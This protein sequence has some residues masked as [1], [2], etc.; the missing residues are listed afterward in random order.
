MLNALKAIFLARRCACPSP[1]CR[2]GTRPAIPARSRYACASPFARR[3]AVER[4]RWRRRS[5]C[6]SRRAIPPQT[7]LTTASICR[8][9]LSLKTSTTARRS[10][11]CSRSCTQCVRPR[12]IEAAPLRRAFAPSHF[13]GSTCA[14]S[15]PMRRSDR[16]VPL[17]RA[18]SSRH[19]PSASRQ[20]PRDADGVGGSPCAQRCVPPRPTPVCKLEMWR[21]TRRAR[22]VHGVIMEGAKFAWPLDVHG[23]ITKQS[24]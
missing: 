21:A 7:S 23:G 20:A 12:P 16:P 6:A 10:C 8:S 24:R 22:M 15:S 5:P 13:V 11:T 4:R 1:P 14:A 9:S 19:V 2:L 18:Q 3:F 17:H